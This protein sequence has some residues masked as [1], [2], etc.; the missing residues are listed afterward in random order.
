MQRSQHMLRILTAQAN[1]KMFKLMHTSFIQSWEAVLTTKCIKQ[2]IPSHKLQW[3]TD[4]LFCMQARL[5]SSMMECLEEHQVQSLKVQREASSFNLNLI[6]TSISNSSK[7]MSMKILLPPRS[8]N[9]WTWFQQFT[10]QQAV[11]TIWRWL[12]QEQASQDSQTMWS[13]VEGLS[14]QNLLLVPSKILQPQL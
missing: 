3:L 9:P 6:L 1:Q 4:S 12:L 13:H 2:S 11:A 14:A 5:S 10:P 7:L 8:K